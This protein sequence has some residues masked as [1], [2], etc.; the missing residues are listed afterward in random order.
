MGEVSCNGA[1][2]LT[3]EFYSVGKKDNELPPRARFEIDLSGRILTWTLVG[4]DVMADSRRDALGEL[5]TSLCPPEQ[6]TE[7]LHWLARVRDLQEIA[8]FKTVF[9]YKDGSQQHALVSL[10]PAKN[11]DQDVIGYIALFQP[12]TENSSRAESRVER[13]S[14]GATSTVGHAL[15]H[16]GCGEAQRDFLPPV[17]LATASAS[18]TIAAVR[19]L[20]DAGIDVGVICSE[21]LAAASWSRYTKRSYSAPNENENC[22]FLSRLLAIGRASPGKF[23]SQHRIRRP[24]S[25]VSIGKS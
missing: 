5:V 16:S 20:G 24:R 21:R 13:A 10:S 15:Q 19:L 6:T 23:C 1:A 18:G 8:V 22:E 4:E 17:L 7:W 14:E 12:F 3:K 9:E 11:E 2:A 25:T